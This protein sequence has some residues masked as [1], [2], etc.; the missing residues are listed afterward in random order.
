MPDYK[1]IIIWRIG[2]VMELVFISGLNP[3]ARKGLGVR[4]PSPPYAIIAQQ[5]EQRTCNAK[6]GGSI[7][8]DGSKQF[9]LQIKFP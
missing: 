9:I 1:A 6:V 4:L 8:S 3:D 7:P 5:V 2:G